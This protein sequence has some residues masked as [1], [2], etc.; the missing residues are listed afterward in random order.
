MS[1]VV[2]TVAATMVP[3][4]GAPTNFEFSPEVAMLAAP[5]GPQGEAIRT[6]RTYIVG[7]HIEK[8]RRGLSVC[9]PAKGVGATLVAVNLAVALA[10]VGLKVLL[11]DGDMRQPGI[12]RFIRPTTPVNGM[13]QWLEGGDEV[14]ISTAIQ[15]DVLEN[16]AVMFSGGVTASA[17]E[18]LSRDRFAEGVERCLRDYD[19]T[20]IDTPPANSCADGRRISNIVGYSVLVAQRHASLISDVKVLARQLEDDHVKLVGTVMSEA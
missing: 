2:E 8:G 14:D 13:R 5:N 6:L 12:E 16:L 3:T 18:L 11:I 17:Q 1:E 15:P 19:I 20:I 10:Q 7:M 4:A 9:A